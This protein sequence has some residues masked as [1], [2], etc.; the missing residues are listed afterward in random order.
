MHG[1][2]ALTK[3]PSVI[4]HLASI[5]IEQTTYKVCSLRPFHV[6]IL[7]FFMKKKNNV[8]KRFMRHWSV[9]VFCRYRE[10]VEV[11]SFLGQVLSR[12]LFG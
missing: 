10:S 9:W 6:F 2:T 7:F 1:E 12:Y 3:E 4:R 11:L 5:A 8:K